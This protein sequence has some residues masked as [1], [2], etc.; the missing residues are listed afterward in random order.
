LARGVNRLDVPTAP[1]T[2]QGVGTASSPLPEEAKP[3]AT[4]PTVKTTALSVQ[5]A[6]AQ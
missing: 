6:V 3:G 1:L 4:S 5:A 2:A